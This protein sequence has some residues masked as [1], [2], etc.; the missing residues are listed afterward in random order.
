MKKQIRI[1]G[2][3]IIFLSFFLVIFSN[4][5]YAVDLPR[6]SQAKVRLS[7]APG[8][9]ASGEITVDNP[10]SE[11]M[12]IRL[13]LEDWYYTKGGDGS[14]EFAPANTTSH[15]CASWIIFSPQEIELAPYGQKKISYTVKVP[16]EAKG[17]YYA[18]LFF[19]TIVGK[20]TG[21]EAERGVDINLVFRLAALFYIEAEGT[22][23]RTGVFENLALE[24][25]ADSGNLAI[26]MDFRNTG[27]TDITVGGLFNIMDKKGF[28]YARGEF[29]NAYTFKG[30]MAKLSASLKKPLSP[31]K[32]D[33]I[34][35]LDIGKALE[36][37]NMGRIAPVTREAEI[38][39][40]ADGEV[41]RV[42]KVR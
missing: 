6:L 41:L 34:L 12:S 11:I 31:G 36:E 17:G 39:I 37:A 29:N 13:Y 24:K 35:T 28:V 21:A 1:Y 33:L 23:T 18:T 14:K 16:L 9:S 10:T 40:G 27:N 38:E 2:A 25:D 19:E 42:G 22:I 7:I 26:K 8:E 5:A 30:E 15:S 4:Y 20:L 32:Y 3:I